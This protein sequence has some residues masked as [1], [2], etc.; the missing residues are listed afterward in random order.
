[1]DDVVDFGLIRHRHREDSLA[2]GCRLPLAFL[3]L[4]GWAA[5]AARMRSHNTTTGSLLGL[6]GTTL[7]HRT[8]LA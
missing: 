7:D 2:G 5:L 1:M 8:R 4:C 3:L 6:W